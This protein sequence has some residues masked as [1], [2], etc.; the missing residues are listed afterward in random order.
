VE[1]SVSSRQTIWEEHGEE[2]GRLAVVC[3]N[4]GAHKRT[5]LATVTFFADGYWVLSNPGLSLSLMAPM[6]GANSQYIFTCARCGRTPQFARDKWRE[7]ITG[8]LSP[9]NRDAG[10]TSADFDVSLVA[11]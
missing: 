4:R 8:P 3:T 1:D 11:F 2:I 10:A 5:R 7:A 9:R 6:A